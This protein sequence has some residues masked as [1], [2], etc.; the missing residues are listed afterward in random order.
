MQVQAP[1]LVDVT[2]ETEATRKLYVIDDDMTRAFGTKCLLTRRMV[3][4]GGTSSS[5]TRKAC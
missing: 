3:E 1:E 5:F 4:R 2:K